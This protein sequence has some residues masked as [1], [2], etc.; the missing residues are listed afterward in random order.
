MA[1]H[2]VILVGAVRFYSVMSAFSVLDWGGETLTQSEDKDGRSTVNLA[3]HSQTLNQPT[4][5]K[6]LLVEDEQKPT[7][8]AV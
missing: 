7:C 2:S 8:S 3:G 6:L 4:P 5:L 1:F